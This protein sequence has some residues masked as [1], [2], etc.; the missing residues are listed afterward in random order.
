METAIWWIRRD[1]RLSDN[2]ALTHALEQAVRV[3]PLFILDSKLLNSP[4]VGQNRVEFLFEG[5]H[6][7]DTDLRTRGSELILREGDPLEVL[8]VLL[9]ET[10]AQ[11]IFAE[12]DVS[13]YA[14]RRDEQV[15]RELPLTLTRGT[16]IHSAQDLLKTDGSPYTV[17]TPF[18][19]RWES[20][21]FPGKPLAAPGYLPRLPGLESM[22]VADSP[23]QASPVTFM[24]GEVEA[25][26]RLE[27]FVDSDLLHYAQAHNRMDLDG[28]SGLSPYLR[29]GMISA[30]QVAWAASEAL[31][32][33]RDEN[34][35][36]SV[37]AWRAE[38]IW[39]DFYSLIL[40]H[41]PINMQASFRKSLGGIRWLEDPAGFSAWAEG[42][43]GYPVVDA[44]MRQLNATGWMHNRARMI[45]A[46][47]LVKD[48]LIDWRLG[49]R[50]FMQHLL[51]GDPASNNGG[52]QWAAGTG[53]DAAPYFRI[54]N[55]V[56]QGEE[57]DPQGAYVR[58]WVA[59]L[60]PVPDEY[61]HTPWTMPA[62]LQRR[63]GCVIG[64]HYP[65][66]IVEHA[67]ARRR[68]LDAYRRAQG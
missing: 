57:F 19:R 17:F 5:L 50:Y 26:R 31:A 10:E 48:L 34:G 32:G 18:K 2:I 4:Y 14:K 8:S 9:R 41:Y 13:P 59:E 22:A 43:T 42:R 1:L 65:Y 35:R 36:K 16:T 6:K 30:R 39:R 66:P 45:A 63:I 51:D 7:L 23:H 24:A 12:A 53:T 54:F 3:I 64:E 38:L 55:P 60:S 49:Q 44:A 25:R 15:R 27:A 52:W 37:D 29:F 28:T 40:D 62:D 56:R 46:S 67:T 68:A 33:A 47:F 20:L 21:P 58:R 11:E 61:I